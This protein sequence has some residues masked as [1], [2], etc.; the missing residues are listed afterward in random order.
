MILR[1][2]TNASDLTEPQLRSRAVGYFFLRII[3]SKCARDR[4]NGPVHVNSKIL[5]FVA[6]SAAEAK[7][8]GCFI[9]GRDV[10]ILRNTLE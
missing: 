3:L 5:K 2:D 4:I 10:I 6:A 9:M 1:A 7:T 8:G